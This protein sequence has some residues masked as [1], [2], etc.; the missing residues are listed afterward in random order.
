M[1]TLEAPSRSPCE[2]WIV[3]EDIAAVCDLDT[4]GAADYDTAAQ[5]ATDVLYELSG[6]QFLGVCERTVRP[7]HGRLCPPA[8]PCGCC[9]TDSIPLAGYPVRGVTEV[10]IDGAVIDPGE[11][12][13]D[14]H[15]FLT[16]MADADGNRQQWPGCQRLDLDDTETDTFAVTYDY[17]AEV[18]AAGLAAA[19]ELGCQLATV[20]AGG[21]CQLPAGATRVTRQGVTVDI[22]LLRGALLGLPLT[23]LF[24]QTYNPSRLKRPPA[25]FSPDIRQ[26]PQTVGL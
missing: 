9:Y 13:L 25:L 14:R 23:N 26:F 1:S 4:T 18:P 21:E 11:Y 7:C 8:H 20:M 15:R 19:A 2:P 10:K 6:R 12:R 24:L 22:D 3:A 16:R 17:G 5:V